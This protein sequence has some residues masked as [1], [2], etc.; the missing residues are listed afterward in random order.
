[1]SFD[2]FYKNCVSF[3]SNQK[4]KLIFLNYVFMISK[5]IHV[6]VFFRYISHR[7]SESR[8]R[9]PW[10][11]NPDAAADRLMMTMG[12]LSLSSPRSNTTGLLSE[13]RSYYHSFAEISFSGLCVNWFMWPFCHFRLSVVVQIICRNGRFSQL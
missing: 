3:S 2:F 12:T 8:L 6:V 9:A 11:I 7:A 4:S 1:M 13:F 5:P 10:I